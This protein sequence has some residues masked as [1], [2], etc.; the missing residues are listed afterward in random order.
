[1]SRASRRWFWSGVVV[2]LAVTAIGSGAAVAGIVQAG[3][4]ET[5]VE[6]YF[7]AV[8]QGRAADALALGAIP[9]GD[10][11]YLTSEV[12]EAQRDV[13]RI[14]QVDIGTVTRSGSAAAVDV[15]YRLSAGGTTFT[16]L[17]TVHLDQ[18]GWRWR[19]TAVAAP[20]SVTADTASTRIA[21]A[22]TALPTGPVLMFPGSLPLQINSDLLGLYRDETVARFAAPGSI[23]VVIAVSTA[24]QAAVAAALDAAVTACLD[25]ANEDPSCPT[26]VPGVPFVPMS[27][28]GSLTQAPSV[29]GVTYEVLPDASG[30]IFASGTFQAQAKWKQL[31]FN[32]LS[33][34]ERGDLTLSYQAT[35]PALEP[36]RVQWGAP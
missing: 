17:D 16:V 4:V 26:T 2:A 35:I 32:N 9:D 8:A 30:R 13:G 18:H 28:T 21:L 12:L 5:T 23:D 10:R 20:V 14:S 24:G 15:S 3:R 7:A 34:A 25:P 31:N 11:R 1:M 29:A 19:M 6:D 27:M 36:I 33:E 22:G